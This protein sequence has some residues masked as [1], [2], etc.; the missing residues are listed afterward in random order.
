MGNC[1]CFFTKMIETISPLATHT[2]RRVVLELTSG[3]YGIENSHC[4]AKPAQKN[5]QV[6]AQDRHPVPPLCE[7]CAG[8][9]TNLAWNV[10]VFMGGYKKTQLL[11]HLSPSFHTPVNLEIWSEQLIAP[12]KNFSVSKSIEI[13]LLAVAPKYRSVS[14]FFPRLRPSAELLSEVSF[15]HQGSVGKG[16]CFNKRMEKTSSY[17]KIP[18]AKAVFSHKESINTRTRLF[19]KAWSEFSK[20]PAQEKTDMPQ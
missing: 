18:L 17:F 8:C 1:N 10:K 20:R 14:A 12:V 3:W 2:E 6:P 19:W 4:T 7:P 13:G 9:Q 16:A 11:R 5:I 15:E